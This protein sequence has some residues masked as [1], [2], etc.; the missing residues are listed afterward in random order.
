MPPELTTPTI[1]PDVSGFSA[2]SASG[3]IAIAAG[4]FLSA[5]RGT[6]SSGSDTGAPGPLQAIDTQTAASNTAAL[7]TVEIDM[8]TVGV[9]VGEHYKVIFTYKVVDGGGGGHGGTARGHLA[10]VLGSGTII[11]A[12]SGDGGQ[13]LFIS[14]GPYASYDLET[15]NAGIV[16]AASSGQTFKVKAWFETGDT[17]EIH[18]DC[19]FLLPCPSSSPFRMWASLNGLN[20]DDYTHE[21]DGWVAPGYGG[22]SSPFGYNGMFGNSIGDATVIDSDAVTAVPDPNVSS[23]YGHIADLGGIGATGS[24]PQRM[25]YT[26]RCTNVG[27]GAGKI[28][29]VI[30]NGSSW[31]T[32][33]TYDIPDDGS[34]Y[35]MNLDASTDSVDVSTGDYGAMIWAPAAQ[36]VRIDMGYVNLVDPPLAVAGKLH[37]FHNGAWHQVK[38]A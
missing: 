23:P 33:S 32:K 6:L 20:Y 4:A 26:A 27:G 28:T 13:L 11:E 35:L 37:Y 8:D 9:V 5:A 14:G 1:I 25:I 38:D 24:T 16:L 22:V 31:D 7:S 36:S 17:G 15:S 19:I 2:G 18:L 34:V 21:F 12:D 3:I 29:A 10:A 30:W